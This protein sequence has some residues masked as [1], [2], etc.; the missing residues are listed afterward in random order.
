MIPF[1]VVKDRRHHLVAEGAFGVGI[2]GPHDAA[3][4]DALGIGS[5]AD[6]AGHRGFQHQIGPFARMVADRQAEVRDADM[7][8]RGLGA[9]DQA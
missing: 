8:D 4:V 2:E 9:D 1:V 5:E 6:G 7:L 3:H